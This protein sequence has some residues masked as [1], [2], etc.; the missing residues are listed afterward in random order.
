MYYVKL[1]LNNNCIVETPFESKETAIEYFNYKIDQ[2][3]CVGFKKF[4]YVE[5]LNENC[6]LF[7]C[8]V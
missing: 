6:V 1:Y 2:K 5:L 7:D 3:T 4:D 8:E